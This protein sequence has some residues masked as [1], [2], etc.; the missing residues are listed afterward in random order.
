MKVK[1][2]HAVIEGRPPNLWLP[3]GSVWTV[4]DVTPQHPDLPGLQLYVIRDSTGREVGLT[5]K[6]C[7]VIEDV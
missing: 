4:R 7:E 6:D 3:R 1:L 5:R 2:R